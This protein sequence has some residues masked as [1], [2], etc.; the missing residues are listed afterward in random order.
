MK[1]RAT[2][3]SWK[4]D[5]LASPALPGPPF[6]E[7]TYHLRRSYLHGTWEIPH[8]ARR[9]YTKMGMPGTGASPVWM[10]M[11]RLSRGGG[12]QTSVQL[13]LGG[14]S[15]PIPGAVQQVTLSA[16]KADKHQEQQTGPSPRSWTLS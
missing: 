2:I 1:A 5:D 13:W 4:N 11:H 7:L 12:G 10:H 16:A 3:F 9:C 8:P 15:L 14:P 6:E